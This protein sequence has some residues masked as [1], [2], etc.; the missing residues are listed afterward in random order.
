MVVQ[1][2]PR[3]TQH[4]GGAA[5]P[6]AEGVAPAVEAG[7]AVEAAPS[8]PEEAAPPEIEM[9][10]E[11][12]PTPLEKEA[13]LK[14]ELPPPPEEEIEEESEM[15]PDKQNASKPIFELDDEPKTLKMKSAPPPPPAEEEE[16]EFE[17][18]LPAPPPKKAAP[19]AAKPAAPAPPGGTVQLEHF[20][21]GSH[22]GYTMKAKS[23]GVDPGGHTEPFK[24]MMLPIKQ[25]DVKYVTEIRAILPC[26]WDLIMLARIIKGEKDDKGRGTIANH[27]A[28]VPRKMLETGTLNYEDIDA[29]M[30]KWESVPENLGAVGDIPLIEVPKATKQ[31]DLGELK[32]YIPK[33]TLD[34]MIENYKK[35]KDRKIFVN[36]KKSTEAQRVKAGYLLSLLLDMKTRVTPLAIF[37]DIPYRADEAS[38]FNLVLSRSLISIKPGGSWI[39]LT[40]DTEGYGQQ[41]AKKDKA[42]KSTIDDIYN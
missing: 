21:Y 30:A 5:R 35:D 12:T 40:A 17:E 15:S 2:R 1:F 6:K 34:K 25:S 32:N 20:L 14:E 33:A 18:E 8:P 24:G 38:P 27:T 16:E 36:Y 31:M 11:T 3:F 37:T 10:E 4:G 26:G 29:A 42:L 9:E 7:P 39:V 28:I 19:P 41:D 23:K 13:K 22:G